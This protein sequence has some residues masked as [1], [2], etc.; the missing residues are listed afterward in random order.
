M[1]SIEPG[2]IVLIVGRSRKVLDRTVEILTDRGHLARATD[3]F[4]AITAQVDP[5][6]LGVVVFGGQVP[7]AKK[8]EMREQ[9]AARN[10]EV[11]FLQGLSGIPGLIA[12][13]VAGVFA[14]EPPIPGQAPTYDAGEKRIAL[15]LFA[16]LDVKV[17]VYWITALVP[18]DPESDSL[19]LHDRPL[20]AG[21]HGF[22]IPAGVSHETAFAT[23]KAGPAIWSFRLD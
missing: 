14:G 3:D 16:A 7:P 12:D 22:G 23:V 1:E 21:D 11:R 8:A 13:Q 20:E 9:I 5:G 19:V 10:G 6:T 2:K 4:E 17:T 18:P 15:S